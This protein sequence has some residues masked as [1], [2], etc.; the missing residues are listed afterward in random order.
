[1]DY[2]NS[3]SGIVSAAVGN[4][5]QSRAVQW[6]LNK[7]RENVYPVYYNHNA[8]EADLILEDQNVWLG[9]LASACDRDALRVRGITRIITAVYD[10]NPIFPD[11]PELIY[12]K[13][14]VLDTPSEQIAAH[15][16]KAIDFIDESMQHSHGVL[17]HCVYGVSR[18]ST[19]MCAYLMRKHN[20]PLKSAIDYV[21]IRRPQVKPNDG[22][23]L[24]LQ[25]YGSPFVKV[26]S[27]KIRSPGSLGS[28]PNEEFSIIPLFH[29][30]IDKDD[31]YQ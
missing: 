2:L 24:Q 7:F 11:D 20:M 8:W 6:P 12:L 13:I 19:L 29:E 26:S 1:M 27:N 31:E 9:G 22:F 21:K 30:P 23:L 17:I 5:L 10:V 28:S 14:P 15:F 25:S 3:A 16:E 18:S 4:I